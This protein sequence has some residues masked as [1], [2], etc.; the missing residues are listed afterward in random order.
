MVEQL[1][2]IWPTAAVG[3]CCGFDVLRIMSR[4]QQHPTSERRSTLIP[5]AYE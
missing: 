4:V 2:S 1:K 3:A 5:D